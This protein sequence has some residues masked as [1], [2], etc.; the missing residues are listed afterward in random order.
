M[1]SREGSA[2]DCLSTQSYLASSAWQVFSVMAFNLMRA[3]RGGTTERRSTSGK[4]R[5]MQPFQTIQMLPD[6]FINRAG[7]L[8]Q[9]RGRQ[10]LDHGSNSMVRERFQVI[11]ERLGCVNVLRHQG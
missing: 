4:R 5:T 3:M 9:P 10:M 6:G 2:F 11:R 1:S 7:L 8:V